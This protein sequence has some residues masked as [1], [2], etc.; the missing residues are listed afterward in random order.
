MSYEAIND[1][2]KAEAEARISIAAA[3]QR[4]KQMCLDA[5]SAGKEAVDAAV[6]KAETELTELN[7]Q[8]D[9]RIKAYAEELAQELEKEKSAL[10]N[11]ADIRSEKA[12][13]YIVERIMVG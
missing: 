8:I 10:R 9:L 1:I 4:A 11:R 13:A 7:R 3:E 5:E 12:A 6:K 2:T